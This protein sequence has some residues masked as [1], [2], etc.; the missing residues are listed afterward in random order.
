MRPTSTLKTI[1]EVYRRWPF[2]LLAISASL[3]FLLLAVWLQ[4]TALLK[5]VLSSPRLELSEKLLFLL[6]S[7]RALETLFTP[8]SRY[9]TILVSLLFGL[10]TGLL[11][12][13]LS[14]RRK[15]IKKLGTPGLAATVLGIFG[16][17]CGSCGSVLLSALGLSG[18]LGLLPLRGVE[19]SLLSVV[20]LLYSTNK[21]T[22]NIGN[23]NLCPIKKS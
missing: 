22:Q 10:N 21:I 8:F 2:L 4:N 9:L 6:G 16:I 15:M 13:Y 5:T 11:V 1:R 3:L 14:R 12:F 18:V 20:L 19:F 7:L 23:E 17:G